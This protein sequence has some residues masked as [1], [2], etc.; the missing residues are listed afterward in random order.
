MKKVLDKNKTKKISGNDEEIKVH[1]DW[2]F[3][4]VVL[5]H[6]LAAAIAIFPLLYH[7]AKKGIKRLTRRLK[8]G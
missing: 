5:M 2:D 6:M 4:R 3:L 8:I 1:L 7:I